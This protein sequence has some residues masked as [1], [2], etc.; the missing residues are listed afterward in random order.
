MCS[1]IPSVE[2]SIPRDFGYTVT[3]ETRVGAARSDIQIQTIMFIC[4]TSSIVERT[5]CA[6]AALVCFCIKLRHASAAGE[7]HGGGNGSSIISR[8]YEN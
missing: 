1:F 2:L 8:K 5:R 7:W 3:R 4:I 6:V